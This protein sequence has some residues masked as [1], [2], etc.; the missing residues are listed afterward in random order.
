MTGVLD[1]VAWPALVED[2]ARGADE[3]AT[4][5][6]AWY[7]GRSTLLHGEHM[8]LAVLAEHAGPDRLTALL[9]RHGH[10]N[11]QAPRV[12]AWLYWTGRAVTRLHG[13]ES[14]PLRVPA[15]DGQVHVDP[16]LPALP[17]LGL[18]LCWAQ[19]DPGRRLVIRSTPDLAAHVGR[20]HYRRPVTLV[21]RT[22]PQQV[23]A[24]VIELADPAAFPHELAHALDPHGP[25]RAA[26]E[27]EQYADHLGGLLARHRPAT[28]GEL[29]PLLDQAEA[30]V[31]GL[32]Q[33]QVAAAPAGHAAAA[34][35]ASDA[36]LPAPG[37]ASVLAFAAL[38]LLDQVTVP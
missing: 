17:L 16:R 2:L 22:G 12:G 20:C 25:E 11:G 13:E 37:F 3:R 10:L 8:R 18:A 26:E 5:R 1:A 14:P 32:R 6:A 28:L 15:G 27:Q 24:T 19:A 4:R 21:H 31:A 23:T 30:H 36:D 34:A 33:H 9:H 35:E 29:G 38:P 7:T